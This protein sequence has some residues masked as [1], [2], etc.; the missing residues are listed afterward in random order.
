MNSNMAKKIIIAFNPYNASIIGNENTATIDQRKIPETIEIYSAKNSG[1]IY[2][3]IKNMVISLYKC[4]SIFPYLSGS[5][6][7]C[8]WIYKY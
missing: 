6:C 1:D 7:Y 4:I 2:Y 3:A 5:F 8:N